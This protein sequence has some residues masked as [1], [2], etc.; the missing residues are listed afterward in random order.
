MELSGHTHGV[1]D[2]AWARDSRLLVSASDDKSVRVW[3]TETVRTG[4]DDVDLV[5]G[6]VDW[7]VAS[8]SDPRRAHPPTHPSTNRAR[9]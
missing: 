7:T 3:D 5:G 9:R 4:W 6:F 1:S 2:V 8:P